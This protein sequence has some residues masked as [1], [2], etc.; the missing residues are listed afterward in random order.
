MRDRR[1]DVRKPR[2][3][4]PETKLYDRVADIEQVVGYQKKVVRGICQGSVSVEEAQD[5]DPSITVK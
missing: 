5:E 2:Q 4:L 1:N 3:W